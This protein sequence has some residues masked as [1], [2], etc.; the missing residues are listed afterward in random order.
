MLYMPFNFRF[1]WANIL[2]GRGGGAGSWRFF[3]SVLIALLT[4]CMLLF[5]AASAFPLADHPN[6]SESAANLPTI[7]VLLAFSMLLLSVADPVMDGMFVRGSGSGNAWQV[8]AFKTGKWVA[9]V[10]C[11]LMFG[12]MQWRFTLL[13]VALLY[14]VGI[15][16][17]Y[18]CRHSSHQELSRSTCSSNSDESSRLHNSHAS[19]E[20]ERKLSKSA[21]APP[22]SQP[23]CS[24]SQASFIASQHHTSNL[25][26][27]SMIQVADVQQNQLNRCI[28]F[29]IQI[30]NITF[31]LIPER[32]VLRCI[33]SD[34]MIAALTVLAMTNKCER[35]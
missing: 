31:H 21:T 34:G 8:I 25:P 20:S 10:V 17:I 19:S 5:A 6:A 14:G 16:V 29:C 27:L 30:I 22:S 7:Y 28:C 23:A 35:L 4:G 3:C 26:T 2:E 1:L 11:S 24:S 32:Q 13:S 15:L 33:C 9:G 12:S 18:V